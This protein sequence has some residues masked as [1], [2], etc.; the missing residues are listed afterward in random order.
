MGKFLGV[1]TNKLSKSP[2]VGTNER[3][4]CLSPGIA[5]FQHH[6]SL[7]YPSVHKTLQY[8]NATVRLQGQQDILVDSEYI[9]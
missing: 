2:G 4:K 7:L 3:G 6:C 1:G 8:F 5:D 9:H